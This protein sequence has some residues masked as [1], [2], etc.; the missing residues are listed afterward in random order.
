[1]VFAAALRLSLVAARGVVYGGGAWASRG[2]LSCCG[3]QALGCAGFIVA[4]RGLSSFS[5]WALERLELS[6]PVATCGIF[7]DQG[8]NLCPLHRQADC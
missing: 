2:G 5:S 8:L 6:C 1:M 4:A 3:G 7:L